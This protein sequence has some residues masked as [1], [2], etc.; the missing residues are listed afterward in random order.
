MISQEFFVNRARFPSSEL[1]KYRGTWVAFSD[2][3]Q[4]IVA[5]QE[6]LEQLEDQLAA[7]GIDAQQLVFEFVPGPEDDMQLGAGDQL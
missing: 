2:D 7:E 1:A 6:K 5:S 3:G 4:R